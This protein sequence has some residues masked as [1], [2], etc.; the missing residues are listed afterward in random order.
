MLYGHGRR[1][2]RQGDAVYD[3]PSA[4]TDRAKLSLY[5]KRYVICL[6]VRA[7]CC[8]LIEFGWVHTQM[9]EVVMMNTQRSV[10]CMPL[11]MPFS[12]YCRTVIANIFS[13]DFI[14]GGAVKT[15]GS[16]LFL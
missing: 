1:G 2:E 3:N 10:M 13:F 5:T 14:M 9:F 8:N 16:F 7:L 11:S 4:E 15:R 12:L 6:Y